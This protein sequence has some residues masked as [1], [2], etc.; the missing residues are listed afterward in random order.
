MSVGCSSW[1]II[2]TIAIKLACDRAVV[3]V[4]RR[5]RAGWGSGYL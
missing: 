2:A 5:E 4:T 1:S 3:A